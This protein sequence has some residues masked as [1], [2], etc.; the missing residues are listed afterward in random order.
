MAKKG[1][2]FGKVKEWLLAKGERA[3]LGVCLFVG[4]ALLVMG[5]MSGIKNSNTDWVTPFE[6][7]AQD[8]TTRVANAEVEKPGRDIDK[9]PVW[10]KDDQP[11]PFPRAP[12]IP[13][14]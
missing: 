5:I 10:K 14:A 4:A 9:I 11:L 12:L 7:G 13:I 1:V 2:D 8:V 6:K 3:A